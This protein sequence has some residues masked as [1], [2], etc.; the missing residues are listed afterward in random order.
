MTVVRKKTPVLAAWILKKLPVYED[1][2]EMTMDFEEEYGQYIAEKGRLRAYFWFWGHTI[3]TIAFYIVFSSSRSKMMFRN[4]LKIALRTIIKQK[5][6]SFIN[7]SGIIISIAACFMILKY[8]GFELSYDDF[9]AKADNLYRL[10]N[11][12]HQNGALI[13][14]G[15]ITYPSVPKAMKA[16]YPEVINYTRINV[17]WR[18]FTSLGENGFDESIM[19]ADS[20]FFS[21]FSFPLLQGDP[22]SVL[23]EPYNIILSETIAEKYF[24]AEWEEKG[25]IGEVLT[26]D[27]SFDLK[28]TGVF[29]DIPENTHMD[30]SIVASFST[31][32]KQYSEYI[33]DSWTNSNYYVYL[34]L[35]QGTDPAVMDEKFVEFCDRYF[36]GTEVTGSNESFFLQ[37]LRD[38]HLHSDYEYEAWV[39]G[40]SAVV[41]AMI[42]I[43][44]FILVITWINFVNLSTARSIDRAKEVGVRK[45][46]GAQKKQ[47]VSQFFSESF[48]LNTFGIIIAAILIKILQPYFSELLDINF[49]SIINITSLD[50]GILAVFLL[51]TTASGMYPAFLTS[52]FK[53]VSVL[54]GKYKSSNRGKF[55]RKG[56]VTFQF[57]LSF[58]LIAATYAVYSQV[59]YMMDRDIGM[60]I[61]Q[62]IVLNSPR[63]TGWS[64]TYYENIDKIRAE[65]LQIPGITGMTTSGRIPG[66]RTGRIFNISIKN[67][68]SDQLYTTSDITVDYRYFDTF[69]MEVLAGR[70]FKRDDHQFQW[71][72]I[73]NVVINESTVKLLGFGSNENAL[74]KWINFWG[75]DWQIVG[76]IKDHHQQALHVP[77][78]P[79]IFTPVYSPGNRYFVKINTDSVSETLD[80]IK[81]KYLEFFPG[82]S[83]SYFFLDEFFN[84]Q[85]LADRNL[86]S[87]F[88]L[89]TSI[90]I[91][92]S[93][94]GLFGLSYFII[95][96]RTKEIGIRK[97]I[98]ATSGSIINLIVKYFSI[99]VLLAA[100]FASPF[101]YFIIRKWLANY[102]YHINYDPGYLLIPAVLTFVIAFVTISY[103]VIKVALLNPV[104]PLKYE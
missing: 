57:A 26:I 75:K 41:F 34:E 66:N 71:N 68:G 39:H 15:V 90:C 42:P 10:T 30:F 100:L 84:E 31:L 82:N 23:A 91:F 20:A 50:I 11:D 98:G 29:E 101:T 6:Y 60:N 92:L 94:L 51:G 102:A 22:A 28:I 46:V 17:Y 56:L 37:S 62:T 13:Q 14:H 103:K 47:I 95:A 97:A 40:N 21:M 54:Q 73:S 52:S 83:F 85:Y 93:C 2:F 25:I 53:T 59:Q 88:L 45:V 64:E 12:R 16:D 19:F 4:Y 8:V 104:E 49:A 38:I 9:H 24:G 27:N 76:V 61:E 63:L 69:G 65:L 74:D 7:V 3:K 86:R 44:I 48:L 72:S 43:A 89:F 32:G 58:A 67:S 55:I 5:L 33:E 36:R 87:A 96:Q 80:R 78:E 79:V 1:Y 35:Q 70:D 18:L 77:A 99:L 81:E